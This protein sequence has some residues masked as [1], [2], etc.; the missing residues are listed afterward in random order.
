MKEAGFKH[1]IQAFRAAVLACSHRGDVNR[2]RDYFRRMAV[3]GVVADRDTFN[4]LLTAYARGV[5]KVG[6]R[7]Q[8][9]HKDTKEKWNEL[10]DLVRDRG[11]GEALVGLED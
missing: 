4:V 2:A 5:G 7:P 8:L 9:E 1:D 6:K 3:E 11:A 10:R